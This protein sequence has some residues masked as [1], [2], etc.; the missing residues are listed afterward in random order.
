MKKLLAMIMAVSMC[1]VSSISS[2]CLADR[3]GETPRHVTKAYVKKNSVS[4]P[5]V[6]ADK[7]SAVVKQASEDKERDKVGKTQVPATETKSVDTEVT[8]E[9]K[10]T[11]ETAK[12]VTTK[13]KALKKAKKAAKK[14]EKSAKKGKK[15]VKKD[16]ANIKADKASK[17]EVGPKT[18]SGEKIVNSEKKSILSGLFKSVTNVVT[19]GA[20]RGVPKGLHKKDH[21][22]TPKKFRKVT[23]TIKDATA[24]DGKGVVVEEIVEEIVEEVPPA[25]DAEIIEDT[26]IENVTRVP[27][28]VTKEEK[29][30]CAR[31]KKKAERAA[32][33]D[34]ALKEKAK[35][36]ETK[37]EIKRNEN[38]ATIEEKI[39]RNYRGDIDAK[40]AAKLRARLRYSLKSLVDTAIVGATIVS[41]INR[42]KWAWKVLKSDHSTGMEYVEVAL[43][44]MFF[45]RLIAGMA[46]DALEVSD[47]GINLF[48]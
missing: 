8:T 24:E 48:I 42:G 15:Y 21:N 7:T 14:A 43:I 40:D 26:K 41:M 33:K 20:T 19:K 47:A 36:A 32:A 6:Q 30:E 9:S 23:K 22:V 13:K 2:M 39:K 11:T 4:G 10:K 3:G 5:A 46:A 35:V 37:E 28:A 1:T 34:A 16:K 18:S 29:I 17:D 12:E 44:I 25:E 38:R 27:E 31:C 45:P